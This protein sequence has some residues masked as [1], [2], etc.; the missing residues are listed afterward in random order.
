MNAKISGIQKILEEHGID[1][2]LI[3]KQENWRY[4]SGFTGSSAVVLVTRQENLF[5]TDFRYFEQAALETKDFEII[6]PSTL[7]EDAVV[8]KII[9]LGLQKIG[10][11]DN[12]LT[13][14]EYSRYREKLSGLVLVPLHHAVE[15]LRVVKDAGEIESI[16]AAAAITDDAFQHILNFIKPGVRESAIALEIDYYMRRQGAEKSAFDIIAASGSRGALPHGLASEKEV[17]I[18]EFIV[19]DFGAVV[20]GYHSDMTRTVL[21][22]EPDLRHKEIYELVL[23]AQECALQ[24]IKPG[25]KCS[26]VDFLARDIISRE[27][28]GANFGHSL[29]HSV[30][31]EIHENPS[32]SPRD[33]TILKPGMVLTVEP[34]I[35]LTNWGGVRIE[36]LIAVT[37]DGCEIL[38]KSPKHLVVL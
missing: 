5:F 1:A 6:R 35:Y 16:R 32:F 29:G 21:L 20:N 12:G 7:V 25:I 10:F 23:K 19:L 2:L 15:L 8:E 34:G 24:G 28:Y 17:A 22:G 26:D 31:L 18:G 30:G 38:S 33:E 3:T 13:Y 27:G 11:E 4:L 36:D 9:G 37:S 14:Y